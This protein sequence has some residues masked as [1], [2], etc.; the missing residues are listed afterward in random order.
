MIGSGF[1]AM[2]KLVIADDEG[3]KT[4]V[5]LVR[6]EVTIGRDEDNTIRLTER[7]VSRRHAKFV[8]H[9]GSFVVADLGSYNGLYINGKRMEGQSVLRDGDRV[10]IGDYE[11]TFEVEEADIAWNEQTPVQIPSP[12]RLVVLTEPIRGVEFLLSKPQQCIGRNESIDIFVNHRS[13]SHEHAEVVVGYD[14]VKIVDLDSANGIRVN[15][16]HMAQS[17]LKPGDLVEVGEVLFR[18]EA[19]GLP[20]QPLVDATIPIE[21]GTFSEPSSRVEGKKSALMP[22]G[23]LGVLAAIGAFVFFGS[24]G[25]LVHDNIGAGS[26]TALSPVTS[27]EEPADVDVEAQGAM[28]ADALSRCHSAVQSADW[29]EAVRR[30]ADALAVDPAHEPSRACRALAER[31]RA[32]T[33]AFEEATRALSEGRID[34]AYA[35]AGRIDEGS[36]LRSSEVY[37]KIVDQ[38]AA[39]HLQKAR[40]SASND[41]DL[42]ESELAKVLVVQ[43]LKE[44]DRRGAQR[45]LRQVE[46]RAEAALT[47]S[48][49]SGKVAVAPKTTAV[50][51]TTSSTKRPTV[52]K[53]GGLEAARA[54]LRH[55]DNQ[56]VV[57][58]LENGSAKSPA[59]VALLIETYLTIGD[60]ASAN[61]EMKKF[62][63]RYPKD[64]RAGRYRQMMGGPIISLEIR[65]PLAAKR[66]ILPAT[67]RG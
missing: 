9:N 14:S 11:I 2:Y 18:F 6:D 38:Y 27:P 29:D 51:T 45:V 26:E 4:V 64:A 20:V 17:L 43:G 67:L 49:T 21:V 46:R 25:N 55:G 30:A 24:G 23:I 3:R 16:K 36:E 12:C 56:C 33:M 34:A 65:C 52:A 44:K 8:K 42:A 66:G 37:Q 22:L 61:E 57:R 1:W 47:S 15:G 59:A 39:E 60:R 63:R 48:S 35:L 28:I 7:N 62:V 13:I 54:C 41:P 19:P 32:D 50:K 5:P 31:G 53:S 58:A 40:V 10:L